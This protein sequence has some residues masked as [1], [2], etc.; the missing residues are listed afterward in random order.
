IWSPN[1]KY[2]VFPNLNFTSVYDTSNWGADVPFNNG[3]SEPELNIVAFAW[4][5]DS[6][7]IN[8]VDDH[9][10]ISNWPVG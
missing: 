10:S 1:G 2:I 3:Q 8:I 6:R 9:N 4:S 7:S 5:P